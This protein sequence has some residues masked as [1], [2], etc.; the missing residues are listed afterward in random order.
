MYPVEHIKEILL[1]HYKIIYNKSTLITKIFIFT[2][3]LKK[4]KG[5]GKYGILLIIV[6][7][8]GEY[9]RHLGV[10]KVSAKCRR[11]GNLPLFLR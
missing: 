11:V 6:V 4:Q 7:A 1:G 2:M 3:R 10:G 9:R 8:V 5:V